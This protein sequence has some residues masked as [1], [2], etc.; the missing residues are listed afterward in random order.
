MYVFNESFDWLDRFEF[1]WIEYFKAISWRKYFFIFT[2]VLLRELR[3]YGAR[4]WRVRIISFLLSH[5]IIIWLGFRRRNIRIIGIWI[6]NWIKILFIDFID[7]Q[8]SLG[9]IF[10]HICWHYG[11]IVRRLNNRP[12]GDGLQIREQ[13]YN[14]NNLVYKITYIRTLKYECVKNQQYL[15]VWVT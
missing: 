3:W 14:H 10:V 11:D 7:V 15:R 9:D 5:S 8:D 2:R 13:L 6:Y 4:I 1:Y 12:S